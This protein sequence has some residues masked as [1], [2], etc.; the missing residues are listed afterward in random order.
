MSKKRIYC[1]V[2]YF[3][4]LLSLSFKFLFAQE[5]TIITHKDVHDQ[6]DAYTIKH[7]YLGKKT[8]WENHEK[9]IFIVF[10]SNGSFDIFLKK[11]IGKSKK[12]FNNYWRRQIFT[13]KGTMPKSFNN[14]DTVFDF[15]KNNRGSI[16]FIPKHEDKIDN[17]RIVNLF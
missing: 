5:L 3:F 6:I 16:A 10:K 1:I 12:Q 14:I 2:I 9:V 11:Y 15:I 8:Q 13:G 4:I 17:I 7:I